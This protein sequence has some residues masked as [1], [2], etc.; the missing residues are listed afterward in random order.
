[1]AEGLSWEQITVSDWYRDSSASNKHKL[2]HLWL[3]DIAPQINPKVLTDKRAYKAMY[4]YVINSDLPAKL[5]DEDN[6]ITPES[7]SYDAFTQIE[8]SS[9]FAAKPYAEQQALK[10]IWFRRMSAVDPIFKTLIPEDQQGYYVN[11]MK[12]APTMSET[13]L[14]FPMFDKQ[15]LTESAE[16]KSNA[17]KGT[18]A[19]IQNFASSAAWAGSALLLGPV[20]ALAGP[21]SVLTNTIEDAQKW[22]EWLNVIN[23]E[24]NQ[25]LT[26]GLPSVLGYITGL[27]G[28]PFTKMESLFAG[29]AKL[30]TTKLVELTPGVLE[31]AGKV[32]GMK[33][34][35]IAFQ[36]AGGAT[37]GALQG[38]G[39]ALSEGK[40]WKTYLARD[41]TYG[42][43]LE[44]AG[45]Y[46]GMMRVVAKAA[47][48][49]GTTVE[50]LIKV[51]L[52]ISDIGTLPPKLQR[53]FS[54][55]P[56]GMVYVSVGK[57]LDKDGL[58]MDHMDTIGGV[59]M[60]AEVLGYT[61]EEG[62]DSIR[63]LKKGK[64]VHE[65]I[66]DADNTRIKNAQRWLD[67]V[68]EHWEV[69]EESLKGKQIMET[70]AAVPQL[71]TRIG[72]VVPEAAR[73]YVRRE[74]VKHG[75]NLGIGNDLREGQEVLD[76]IYTVIQGG[77]ANKADAVLRAGGVVFDE[78]PAE[79]IATI[80]NMRRELGMLNSRTA[81]AV[82][83]KNTGKLV[84]L[85]DMPTTL[86]DSPELKQPF[87]H[88]ETFVGRPADIREYFSKLKKEYRDLRTAKTRVAKAKGI[89][90]SRYLDSQIVEMK[91]QVPDTMGSLREVTLHFPSVTH[92]QEAMSMARSRGLKGLAGHIFAGNPALKQSYN[93]YVKQV[94]KMDPEMY[95][96][97][98]LPYQ[99]MAEQAQEEEF[100]LGVLDGK[101]II[102]DMIDD[103]SA[104][105]HSFNSLDE[106][107]DFLRENDG[108]LT[109]PEITHM[110][111][112]AAEHLIKHG[113]PDPLG[114]LEPMKLKNAEKTKF[115]LRYAIMA[116]F[117]PSQYM[118]QRFEK[119]AVGLGLDTKFN[120]SPMEISHNVRNVTRAADAFEYTHAG[121]RK[122]LKGS[123]HGLNKK[124]SSF[125]KR[126]T[127]AA[128]DQAEV[129][130]I[131][132][133]GRN[134]EMQADVLAEMIGAFGRPR[135][136]E[137]IR[138]ATTGS[139]YFDR[140]YARSGMNYAKFIKGYFPH[141][142]DELRKLKSNLSARP[143]PRSFTQIPKADRPAFFEMA[144]AADPGDIAFNEDYF[145]MM[146][147]YTHLMARKLFVRPIMKRMADS[148]RKMNYKVHKASNQTGDYDAMINYI[149]ELFG[150]IEGIQLPSEKV[151]KIATENTFNSLY[152]TINAKWGTHLN[153][154]G[155]QD[156]I[157]KA[158]MWS[159]GAHIAG[160]PYLVG[161]NSTQSL[162]L[163]GSVIGLRWWAE[164][165][166]AA[167]R[168][169]ALEELKRIGQIQARGLPVAA[170]TA[171][172]SKGILGTAVHLGMKPYKGAD[173]LNRGIVYYG[174]QKR[175][176]S[177][178]DLFRRGKITHRRFG[179]LS[180]A[181]L[182][183]REAYNES[184]KYF[185]KG[186]TPD[187]VKGFKDYL[188][189]LAV[190][191]TQILY[192]TFQQP[193][194]FRKGIGRFFGQYTSW[195]INF[196]NLT[197]ERMISDTLTVPEKLGYLARLG[198]TTGAI[199]YGMYSVGMNPRQFA[200]WNM[201][202]VGGGPYY[203]VM[204]DF[205]SAL[206]GSEQ[207]YGKMVRTLTNLVP[208]AYE[209]EGVMRAVQ[210]MQ[211][212]D[213]Y[214]AFLH[215]C[216]APINVDVYPRR[217]I[218]PLS[219][220]RSLLDAGKKFFEMKRAA[221]KT[222]GAF[223]RE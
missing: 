115:G 112:E 129:E 31:S 207:A 37:A 203:Q 102:Q 25:I 65:T 39:E 20:R 79:N 178:I 128:V 220:E 90:V 15:E 195:P 72:F 167:T 78:I 93:D 218:D 40:D 180:G 110:S 82:V 116:K 51:P 162:V 76:K 196:Y 68:D 85:Q 9:I 16:A 92:A 34:P 147:M 26:A 57:A 101:Y 214:E 135:A 164:G 17:V 59:R 152:D 160:R 24:N 193:Q 157:S 169:G 219:I 21:D 61:V 182:F 202:T 189:M 98:F 120:F 19:F 48:N 155:K 103:T 177:A 71:K 174:M 23:S 50:D 223:G 140:L 83:N 166:N 142:A 81:F 208:F 36:T 123:L 109:S 138:V 114:E 136:N 64:L 73:G 94:R 133:K 134:Y 13:S 209:G 42:T 41:I 159:T 88:Q 137:L 49:L 53:L 163:G 216:S 146:E 127:E 18:A 185:Q 105:W 168:P 77:S 132:I 43:I 171:L 181:K 11:L 197:K 6:I 119:L 74:L 187:A 118:M 204:N 121:F 200:P 154:K 58:V 190:D 70:V 117:A 221:D 141:Y 33:I 222:W 106:V 161:R 144:R 54:V 211:E 7:L 100:Y 210:A 10:Q 38:I 179:R 145:Y 108:R 52:K 87:M 158:L 184:L 22:K 1:M 201:M 3:R 217:D 215:I 192:D 8:R 198:A 67:V 175:M 69:W 151:L 35:S 27:L 191:R 86:W 2:K 14:L 122:K 173:W 91:L 60:K 89:D 5:P 186:V 104:K 62:T 45:R 130:S 80:K 84:N 213:M 111:A 148:I 30:G 170:G 149:G 55:S 150:S 63:F 199:A 156:A 4:N 183:G 125:L 165:L 29:G 188:S 56:E 66:A 113:I 96:R 139:Q 153:F 143:D 95:K 75:I 206:N 124:E 212:G 205:L 194:M 32:M 126:W 44:F 12:R 176:D 46:L 107:G 131:G 97:D 172:Q 28:G 99:F 47:K